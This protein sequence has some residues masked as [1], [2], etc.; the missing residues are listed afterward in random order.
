MNLLIQNQKSYDFKLSMENQGLK[1]YSVYINDGLVLTLINFIARSTL[2]AYTFEWVKVNS[3][4][5]QKR[6]KLIE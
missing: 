1:L 3:G 5:L 6:T 4:N 2:V